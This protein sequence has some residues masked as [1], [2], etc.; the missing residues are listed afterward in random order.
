MVLATGQG[1]ILILLCVST[2]IYRLYNMTNSKSIQGVGNSS[3]KLL[4]FQGKIYLYHKNDSKIVLKEKNR[5]NFSIFEN[6]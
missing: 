3:K 5:Q 4:S 6:W 1:A 2:N